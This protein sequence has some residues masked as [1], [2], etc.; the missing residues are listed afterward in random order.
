[1]KNL[2]Q[3]FMKSIIFIFI[4]LFCACNSVNYMR[5]ATFFQPVKDAE[6]LDI[7]TRIT[8]PEQ[9]LTVREILQRFS[10]GTMLPPDID[11][12]ED[13]DIDEDIEN[14]FDD[15]VDAYDSIGQA[16]S[17]L[18]EESIRNARRHTQETSESEQSGETQVSQESAPE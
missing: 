18:Y 15:F 10:R 17:K 11:T 8:I 5:I 9:S 12:G 1:M 4:G 14:S 3:V 16:Q 6:H 7:N 2:D 13:D